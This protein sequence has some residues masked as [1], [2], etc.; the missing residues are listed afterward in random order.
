MK[1]SNVNQTQLT[2]ALTKLVKAF[3]KYSYQNFVVGAVGN[4]MY[5]VLYSDHRHLSVNLPAE[6]ENQGAIAVPGKLLKEII[7]VMGKQPICMQVVGEELLLTSSDNSYTLEGSTDLDQFPSF[8]LGLRKGEVSIPRN[9]IHRVVAM[10]SKE[11]TKQALTGINFS[12]N[13]GKIILSATD[14]HT[15]S[16]V[17]QALDG[18]INPY[19]W[20]VTIPSQAFV[21]LSKNGGKVKILDHDEYVVVKYDNFCSIH[22]KFESPYPDLSKPLEDR[23]EFSCLVNRKH[24]LDAC[25]R[26][27]TFAKQS[28]NVAR[29]IFTR[30]EINLT[31]EVNEISGLKETIP[32][33]EQ[34]NLPEN[35]PVFIGGN[36]SYII[37]LLNSMGDDEKVKITFNDGLSPLHLYSVVKNQHCLLMPIYIRK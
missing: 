15:L 3:D 20:D 7:S 16:S 26:I 28:R 1:L 9:L 30:E 19:P 25:K 21:A 8:T 12:L 37:K 4:K 22:K 36:I 13:A 33:L 35:S 17:N 11:E 24:L 10:V 6:V 34:S 5:I 29:I 27:Q 14:G 18:N 32:L 31:L 23:N 2:Q